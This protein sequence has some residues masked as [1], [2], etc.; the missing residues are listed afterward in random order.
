MPISSLKEKNDL[1]LNLEETGIDYYVVNRSCDLAYAEYLHSKNIPINRQHIRDLLSIMTYAVDPIYNLYYKSEARNGFPIKS[2]LDQCVNL[3]KFYGKHVTDLNIR[4]S[5]DITIYN[6]YREIYKYAYGNVKGDSVILGN[7]VV[8][9][10]QHQPVSY[11][12]LCAWSNRWMSFENDEEE[13]FSIEMEV[14]SAQWKNSKVFYKESDM[15]CERSWPD[16]FYMNV[17]EK[18][19]KVKKLNSSLKKVG[20][21]CH[22]KFGYEFES[23][24]AVDYLTCNI[25]TEPW[26][27]P[28][29]E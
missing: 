15:I 21:P 13:N 17:K 25:K 28:A 2:Q 7:A 14:L 29:L 24:Y 10:L 1:V 23:D 16:R 18:K 20:I 22:A 26:P 11:E 3:A 5:M 6:K 12:Q 27:R 8:A 4:D 9:I 19:E